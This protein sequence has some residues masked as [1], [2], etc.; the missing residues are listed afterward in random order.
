MND[1]ERKIARIC[2]GNLHPKRM[3]DNAIECHYT[4][5]ARQIIGVIKQIRKDTANEILQE[6]SRQLIDEFKES[7]ENQ[8]NTTV[9]KVLKLI[10]PEKV[11][12][13]KK[14]CAKKYGVEVDDE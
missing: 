2:C 14:K 11:N 1:E 7:G 4:E 9:A 3:C 5:V 12:K 10:C 6:Y 8:C 13:I